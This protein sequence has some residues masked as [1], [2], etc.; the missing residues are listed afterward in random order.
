MSTSFGVQGSQSSRGVPTFVLVALA[1][2]VAV[3]LVAHFARRS[4][5]GP[6]FYAARPALTPGALNPDVTQATIRETICKPGWTRTVRPPTSYT[7][8]LKLEQ[9]RRYGFAGGPADYQEDHFISL[10]LGGHPTD[11]KNLWPERRPRADHVDA[12]END[13]NDQVCS[14]AISLT[15]GQRREAEMKWSD[16]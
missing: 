3:A 6:E 4:T 2:V 15:E 7:N 11:A 5:G 13:L 1:M 16:G 9:L 10:E 14:G 12:I 8:A